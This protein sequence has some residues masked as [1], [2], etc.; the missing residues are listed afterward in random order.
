MG[1]STDRRPLRRGCRTRSTSSPPTARSGSARRRRS[2]PT[3]PS[4]RSS[5]AARR[6]GRR[7]DPSRLRVPVGERGLRARRDRGAG[8]SSSGRRRQPS[9]R[10]AT[11]WPPGGPRPRR[12]CR[13]SRAP[14]VAARGRLGRC[15]GDRLPGHAEGRRR[16]R[17][18][19]H[20][21][22][23]SRRRPCRRAGRGPARGGRG[24]RRRDDLRRAARDPRPPRRGPAARRPARRPGG[25]GGAGLLA[26]S[27]AT[28]SSSRSRRRPPS[29]TPLARRSSSSARR[30]AGTVDFHN[31]ATVEFLLDGEG[32][33]FF[34]EMNTRLQVEHGVTELVTGLDLVAWQI[35]V[36]AGERAPGRACWT[37]A[38]AWPRHRGAA[39]RGGSLRRLPADRR[40]HHR[41]AACR[42]ARASGS[43]PAWPPRPSCARSTTRSSPRSWSMPSIG[44]P[45]SPGCGVRWTRPSSAASR[46]M[47]A[48]CAGSSM[49]TPSPTA[50][51]DTSLIAERWG[52]GPDLSTEERGL[53][54]L[55][56]AAARRAA[57]PRRSRRRSAATTSAWGDLA[58]R[59]ALRR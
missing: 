26:S 13:S 55:A 4:R 1:I 56:A 45:P 48:S 8:W 20:A 40:P 28:R 29:T 33:H 16:R 39:L 49:T 52:S 59:E 6:V 14:T 54:A 7:G 30:V 2:S 18:S 15:G 11:S 57:P 37:R 22:G 27:A 34:L 38:A 9:S 43:T 32:S 25:A 50:R 36:A 47:P 42:T 10:W 21:A 23:R 44:R 24:V 19:G 5:T 35:R 51:Y 12:E 17:R 53:A 31:A 41:L 58:R 46:P 3:S